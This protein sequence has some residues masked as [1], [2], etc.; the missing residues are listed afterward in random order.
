[1]NLRSTFDGASVFAR[2]VRLGTALPAQRASEFQVDCPRPLARDFAGSLGGSVAAN[3]ALNKLS[4]QGLEVLSHVAPAECR[5]Q[6]IAR[7]RN[8]CH[9]MSLDRNAEVQ[10]R[11]ILIKELSVQSAEQA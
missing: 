10:H 3:A 5:V 7:V 6:V 2:C 4:H 11:R 1:M 8:V 9:H